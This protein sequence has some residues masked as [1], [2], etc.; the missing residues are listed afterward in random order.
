MTQRL[1]Q[2]VLE[3][4]V[5]SARPLTVGEAL[6][7]IIFINFALSRLRYA[8]VGLTLSV[9]PIQKLDRALVPVAQPKLTRAFACAA[10]LF[11]ETSFADIMIAALG[12]NP[13]PV[14]D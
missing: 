3:L 12:V 4:D 1:R 10:S 7:V 8:T 14:N 6:S 13:A 2:E 5:R 9:S 11:P